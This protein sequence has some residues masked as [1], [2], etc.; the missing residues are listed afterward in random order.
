MSDEELESLRENPE[1][2]HNRLKIYAVRQ[3]AGVFLQIQ[4]EFGLFDN[5]LWVFVNGAPIVGHWKQHEKVPATTEISD[6]LFSL[7]PL[8]FNPISDTH[9]F[10][11]PKKLE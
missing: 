3:N 2:I 1:I 6:A 8:I 7:S 5:Y 11:S 10:F 4:K 9:N